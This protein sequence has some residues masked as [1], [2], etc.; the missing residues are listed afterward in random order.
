MQT[1]EQDEQLNAVPDPQSQPLQP[2]SIAQADEDEDDPE[3][4]FAKAVA[5]IDTQPLPRKKA[6]Y[7][8]AYLLQDAFCLL[9]I[10]IGVGGIIWQCLTYPHVLVVLVTKAR[11]AE[12]TTTLDIPTR[13]LVPTTITRSA[14][15]QTTGTGHQNARAATGQ[16][17]F[18]NGQAQ[19]I[20]VPSG[21]VFTGRDGERIVTTQDAIIPAADSST[22]PPTYGYTTVSA[23]AVHPGA[24]GNIAAF[25]INGSCCA[26]SVIVKNLAAFTNGQ[27][28]RTYHAVAPQDLTA[29]TSTV[30]ETISQAFTTVFP[31]QHGEEA[32]P[33][34]CH[35]ITTTNHQEGQEARSLTLGVSKTCS[36]VT[37]SSKE[38]NYQ[39][40]AAFTQTKPAATYHIVGSV[41]TTLKSVIPLSVTISGK[42]AYTFSQD[43]EQ[44]LAQGIQGES[45]ARAKAY[46]LKAGVIS[47]ASVPATLPSAEYINFLV[48]VG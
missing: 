8:I 14:T 24:S 22:T 47:Y 25:D 28:A 38:L 32:V 13:T 18:Y 17:T 43:Y 19:S 15:I 33:T 41:Q 1:T 39:A 37:Y 21:S 9:M 23:Q 16:V 10:C 46:L 29:L 5:E 27:D 3:V 35:T 2:V 12:I 34:D 42:W 20:T 44:L 36:A 48:L 30:N 45:P 11:P 26:S 40:M 7:R 6:H 4:T 31:V